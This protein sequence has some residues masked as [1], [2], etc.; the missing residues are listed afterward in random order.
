M[1]DLNF[2]EK[3]LKQVSSKNRKTLVSVM[4][5]N[6]ETGVIQPIKDVVELTRKY[7]CLFHCDAA[8]A[9]G[10]VKIDFKDL[11]AD[12]LTISGHKIGAPTG[13]GALVYDNS[14]NLL[15]QILGGGQENG[16]RSGTENILGIRGFGEAASIMSKC[17]TKIFLTLRFLK[18][19]YLIKLESL[20]MK[21]SSLHK[22]QDGG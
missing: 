8:Q 9:L 19:I 2:L 17:L 1:V 15:P 4:W 11:G 16:M 10:K 3:L 18:I 20:G 22:K 13:I 6:N 21:L 12:F 14:F 5:V 7:E